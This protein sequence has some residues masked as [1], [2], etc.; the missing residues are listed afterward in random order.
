[1][2]PPKLKPK[3]T[4]QIPWHLEAIILLATATMAYIEAHNSQWLWSLIFAAAALSFGLTFALRFTTKN[5][6]K[7]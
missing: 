4:F 7:Q 3:K 5:K 2:P 6:R 1:M